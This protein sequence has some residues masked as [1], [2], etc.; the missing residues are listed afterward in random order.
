MSRLRHIFA[1]CARIVVGLTFV[2]SG[3]LKAVD[4]VG[5][6]LKVQEYLVHFLPSTWIAGGGESFAL[7]ISFILCGGEFILGAFLLM[8]IYRKLCARVSVLFMAG[9]TALT[10][11]ILLANPVS[12][13]GCFGDAFPLTHLQTFLK[14]LV[15]LPLTIFLLWDARTLRHLYSRRERWVPGLLAVL[16]IGYFMVENYRLLP[17]RDFRP[18]R[19]GT[20]LRKELAEEQLHLQ[21]SLLESTQYIYRKDGKER[22]FSATA[23]PDS[24]WTF[25]EARS[26][27]SLMEVKPKYDFNPTDSLGDPVA[28]ILLDS[29]G[30]TLL[31]LTP[32]WST[33]SQGA[34]DEIAE[35]YKQSTDRG[36]AFYGVS[37]SPAEE[38]QRWSYLTG[39][40]Y[41]M[42]QLDATPIRTIIRSQPGLVVLRDGKVIDKRAPA[43]FPE[44]EAVSAYLDGL[45]DP[46][47][48]LPSPSPTRTY[49]LWGWVALL[50][51]GFL[52]FWARK[53]H[54]TVHLHLRKRLHLSK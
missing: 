37:A 3:L 49:L 19:I 30:V 2:F 44:V 50:L 54:L 52:R 16:G 41:P 53:L 23:L 14:N 48:P 28:D 4:P 31:L 8:G 10:L 5:T 45:A 33:A 13:C 32:S 11:Y 47:R 15:L 35:L 26:E 22:A 20:D 17:Y 21:T 27:A 42:L 12:D 38:S 24:S 18:Y 39:A 51:L 9:M 34:I 7:G 36:Y 25:V 6:A 29:P 46:S 1:E 43:S 40:S